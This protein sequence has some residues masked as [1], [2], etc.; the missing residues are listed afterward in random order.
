MGCFSVSLG[1]CWSLRSFIAAVGCG[2]EVQETVTKCRALTVVRTLCRSGGRCVS[3][4][5][6]RRGEAGHAGLG[7]LNRPGFTD[8]GSLGWVHWA[9][10]TGLG[11]LGWV[12]WAGFTGLGSLGSDEVPL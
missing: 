1:R 7:W 8:L 3:N 12:H 10:F 9:G 5:S 11:S 4:L 2:P 6:R